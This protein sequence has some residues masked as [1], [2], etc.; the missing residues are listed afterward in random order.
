MYYSELDSERANCNGTDP[1]LFFPNP[2]DRWTIIKAQKICAVCEIRQECLQ[3]ALDNGE[4]DGIWGGAG[5][6][7]RI[8]MKY[9][10]TARKEHERKM[11][12]IAKKSGVSNE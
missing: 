6:K 11:Q 1:D 9:S 2:G 7:L 8:Q 5:E 3:V 4:K 10:K 12:D